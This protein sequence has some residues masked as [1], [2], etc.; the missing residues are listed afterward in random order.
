MVRCSSPNDV[1]R[2]WNGDLQAV[3]LLIF[4]SPLR[5]SPYNNWWTLW[6][7]PKD[8]TCEPQFDGYGGVLT[9]R[10][11]SKN[12]WHDE[13]RRLSRRDSWIVRSMR[14]FMTSLFIRWFVRLRLLSFR[15]IRK[16]RKAATN[17]SSGWC[18]G[19]NSS[20]TYQAVSAYRE[21][22]AE[23]QHAEKY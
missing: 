16:K 12:S 7:S 20:D 10:K 17:T 21:R 23:M 19:Q 18:E 1:W 3:F 2:T 14:G 9:L 5:V 13:L 15:Q 11:C 4:V 6:R 22:W 8:W